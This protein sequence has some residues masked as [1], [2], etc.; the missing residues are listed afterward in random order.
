MG[1][2][3]SVLGICAFGDL[4]SVLSSNYFNEKWTNLLEKENLPKL[5]HDVTQHMHS[6]IFLLRK[7]ILTNKS[8]SGCHAVMTSH[9]NKMAACTVGVRR[10]AGLCL[11]LHAWHGAC[12]GVPA[13]HG[14]AYL[15]VLGVLSPSSV[16]CGGGTPGSSLPLWGNP[17]KSPRWVSGAYL[18]GA[19][20]C[21]ASAL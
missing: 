1:N 17:S 13:A 21:G 3:I 11:T 4:C 9:C 14:E 19:I 7:L 16:W 5:T 2:Q 20:D 10:W 6:I 12:L 8:L 15:G 18:F